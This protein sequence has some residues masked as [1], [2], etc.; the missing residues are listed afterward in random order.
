VIVT[1]EFA[2][3]GLIFIG[4]SVAMVQAIILRHQAVTAWR[5]ALGATFDAKQRK[6]ASYLELDRAKLP[7]EAAAKLKDSRRALLAGALAGVV[8]YATLQFVIG[9]IV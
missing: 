6:V 8:G 1:L 2:I 5:Q 7:P 9:T 4:A 3:V